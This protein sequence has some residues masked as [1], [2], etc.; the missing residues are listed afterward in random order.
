MTAL[1][2][3]VALPDNYRGGC[4]MRVGLI[5]AG[6]V[7]TKSGN[8]LYARQLVEYLR[9]HGDSVEVFTLPRTGYTRQLIG[10]LSSGLTQRVQAAQLDVLLQDEMSHPALLRLNRQLRGTLPIVSL[11]RRLRSAEQDVYRSIERRYLA[12]VAGFICQSE[13]TQQAVCRLLDRTELTRSVVVPPG[14]DRFQQVLTPEIISQRAH[15]PGPLRVVFVGDV[16][17]RKG[18]LILLEALLKLPSG[19]CQLAVVGNTN[20]DALHLRVVYH[21]LMVTQLTGVTLTGVIGDKEL[22]AILSRSHLMAVPASYSGC[23]AAYLEGMGF[24]LPAIGTTSGAASEI[25]NDGVNGYLVPPNDPAAVAHCLMNLA[26]NQA[27][28]AQLSLAAR[29][30][31]LA[32]PRWDENMAR[33]R[34]VLLSWMPQRQGSG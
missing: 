8:H 7:E 5:I 25:I 34:E 4:V 17:R 3:F 6:D 10:N 23:G 13:T 29:E 19:T 24:G 18:L 15:E 20:L 26:S 33:V 27:Q 11:V 32:R 16:I 28:L 2:A 14:G 30:A 21:L 22:A 12:S 31:F 9:S 1:D